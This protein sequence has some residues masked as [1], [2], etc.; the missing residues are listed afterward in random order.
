MHNK[1][2]VL[3]LIGVSV[4]SS[5]AMAA[6]DW[7]GWYL[8]SNISYSAASS[9][10]S[11][12]LGGQW[13]QES[14]A[15]QAFVTDLGSSDLDLDGGTFGLSAGYRHEFD[16][17]WVVGVELEIGNNWL[18][19]EEISPIRVVPDG[20][21]TEFVIGQQLEIKQQYALRPMVGYA[22]DRGLLYFT[23]GAA[24][25]DFEAET[26]FANNAGYGKVGG[27]SDSFDA[28]QAGVGF[29][30]DTGTKWS[31]RIEYLATFADDVSF[32]TDEF[33]PDSIQPVPAFTETFSRDFDSSALR[34]GVSYRF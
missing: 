31:L 24:S 34:F 29:E 26:A 15:L 1:R 17:A 14:P 2:I 6:P 27:S 3:P 19:E 5:T 20:S 11:V 8:H 7:N 16:S 22:F 25:I 12:K 4:I 13:L 28:Y 30:F 33:L 10:S 18:E 9:G 23:A 32:A 21:G